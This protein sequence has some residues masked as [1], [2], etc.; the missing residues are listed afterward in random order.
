MPVPVKK[1]KKILIADDDRATLQLLSRVLGR[2]GYEVISA[3]DAY[4]AVSFARE[5][6]P[7]LIILDIHMPAGSGISVQER[8]RNVGTLSWKPVIYV[9]GDMSD[10]VKKGAEKAGAFAV[11]YKP[12]DIAKLLK[13]VQAALSEERAEASIS[14]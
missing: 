12:L 6:T 13:T 9:T 5:H 3:M 4:Y 14:V 10:A 11:I 2:S 7:D 1:M 8:I